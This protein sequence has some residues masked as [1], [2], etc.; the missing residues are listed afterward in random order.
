MEIAL[1]NRTGQESYEETA[2]QD[3]L[4]IEREAQGMIR[5]AEAEAKRILSRGR[6]EARQRHLDAEAAARA[7]ADA[8]LAVE[9]AVIDE[10]VAQIG[11]EAEAQVAAWRGNA[12]E[13][14]EQVV[15]WVLQVI[16]LGGAE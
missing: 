2:L 13:H 8:Q 6:E 12:E 11:R 16:T 15:A 5:D 4:A 3:I 14:I 9:F 7:E 10:V 1:R